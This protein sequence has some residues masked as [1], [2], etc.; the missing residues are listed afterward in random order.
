MYILFFSCRQT[1]LYRFMFARFSF[2][3][4]FYLFILFFFFSLHSSIPY[5][6]QRIK[7]YL[8]FFFFIQDKKKKKLFN[9]EW[10]YGVVSSFESN[11]FLFT[12][13]DCLRIV[14]KEQLHYN[15]AENGQDLNASHMNRERKR[16]IRLKSHTMDGEVSA[17]RRSFQHDNNKFV[18]NGDSVNFTAYLLT[19]DGFHSCFHHF[20][21]VFHFHLA[22]ITSILMLLLRLLCWCRFA[23]ANNQKSAI[24]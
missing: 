19:W 24:S 18:W 13:C 12:R 10:C 4:P 8:N 22:I 3:H 17:R 2:L 9:H 21:S 16:E 23:E 1:D 6:R 11:C 15:S 5:H 20:S 7:V 14:Q